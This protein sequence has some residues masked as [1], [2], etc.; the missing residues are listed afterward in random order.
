MMTPLLNLI[1]P[2][3]CP[4]CDLFTERAGF[5]PPCASSLIEGAKHACPSCAGVYVTPPV[6]GGDHLCGRCLSEPP[7]WGRAL[8]AY[9]YGAAMKDALVRWKSRP[10]PTLSREMC[11]LMLSAHVGRG[12]EALGPQTLVCP[13][14]SPRS[15]LRARGFNPSGLLARHMGRHF[16]WRVILGLALRR[17]KGSSK[18]L[19]ASAR[20]RRLR[21]LFRAESRHVSGAHI[22]LVDDVMTSG[23]TVRAASQVLLKAGAHAVDLALLARAPLDP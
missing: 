6:G 23:A 1:W 3:T 19:S 11:R 20:A 22:V 2:P 10:D 18:G 13:I 12:W 17:G 15:A 5:C 21:G 16:G 14:P 9:A 8:A 4:A 7:P